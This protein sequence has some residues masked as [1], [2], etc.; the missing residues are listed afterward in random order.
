MFISFS[1]TLL[2]ISGRIYRLKSYDT[3]ICSPYI[4]GV[5]GGRYTARAQ[6]KLRDLTSLS[7]LIPIKEIVPL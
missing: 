4:A 5:W 3:L 2:P 1:G 6:K 7:L